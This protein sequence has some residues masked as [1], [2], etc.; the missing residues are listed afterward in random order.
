MLGLM[1]ITVIAVYVHSYT[2]ADRKVAV[3]TASSI[4]GAGY[5]T[6]E[7]TSIGFVREKDR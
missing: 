5:E 3:S 1:F 4:H 7:V 6:V 2:P